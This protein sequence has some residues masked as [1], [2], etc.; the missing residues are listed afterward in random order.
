MV[1]PKSNSGLMHDTVA[2]ANASSRWSRPENMMASRNMPTLSK[3]SCLERLAEALAG[4]DANGH[5]VARV[6]KFS[7]T[8]PKG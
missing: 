8:G 5:G 6:V 2:A 7:A 4:V 1:A 3:P